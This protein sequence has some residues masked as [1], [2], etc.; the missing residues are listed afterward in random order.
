MIQVQVVG[1][2]KTRDL[3][4]NLPKELPKAISKECNQFMKDVQKSAK[5]RAPRDTGKLSKSIHVE[6]T[7]KNQWTLIVDSPY[8]VY[9]ER[10]FRPHFI[11][12][13]GSNV[14]GRQSNKFWATGFHWVS[15]HTPFIKPALE[16]NLNKLS[17]KMSDATKRGISK[18][19]SR[20]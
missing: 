1:I 6:L 8:G 15:K 20:K 13:K 11:Y 5:L 2:R 16:H 9:Q 14:M 17:Q 7:G 3:M 12:S 19:R 4:I 18:S 10:G